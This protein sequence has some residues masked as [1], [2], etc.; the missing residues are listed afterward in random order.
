M[1]P[2]LVLQR[3]KIYNNNNNNIVEEPNSLLI[4]NNFCLSEHFLSESM[5]GFVLLVDADGTILYVTESV[6]IFIGLTQV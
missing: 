3:S 2:F 4:N 5:D 1:L 6:A